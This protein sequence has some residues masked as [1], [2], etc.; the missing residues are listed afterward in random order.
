MHAAS[1][2]GT[3]RTKRVSAAQEVARHERNMGRDY[4]LNWRL[5][6]HC[7]ADAQALC[8]DVCDG[9][10]HACGG[11][12]LRC[13]MDKKKD[14]KH[15]ACRSEVFYFARMDVRVPTPHSGAPASFLFA[16]CVGRVCKHVRKLGR[17]HL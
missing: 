17:K 8:A 7:D 14:L 1:V 12:V 2:F 6:K 10:H 15:E 5:H 16:Q 13:L 11:K 3:E 9:E 4:R